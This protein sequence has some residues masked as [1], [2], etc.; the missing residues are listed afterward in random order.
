MFTSINA[1]ESWDEDKPR[2]IMFLQEKNGFSF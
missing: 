2:R 1:G